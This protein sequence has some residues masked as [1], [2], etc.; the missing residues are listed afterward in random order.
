M[1]TERV[2]SLFETG[3]VVTKDANEVADNSDILFIMVRTEEQTK[4]LLFDRD[5]IL[6]HLRKKQ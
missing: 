1:V 4:E 2:E 3:A 5:G 6:D